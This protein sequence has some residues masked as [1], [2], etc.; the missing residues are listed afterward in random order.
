[1][2]NL[3]NQHVDALNALEEAAFNAMVERRILEEKQWRAHCGCGPL[4]SASEYRVMRRVVDRIMESTP[5]ME[6]LSAVRKAAYMARLANL[7]PG[8]A[9]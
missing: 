5:E 7:V 2:S 9:A 3:Q 1:M 4:L 6:T 8:G